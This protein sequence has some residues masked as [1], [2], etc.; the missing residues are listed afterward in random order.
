[1][2]KTLIAMT[3]VSALALGFS[4][5]AFGLGNGG[6]CTTGPCNGGNGNGN[7]HI[8]NGNSLLNVG[9]QENG[10]QSVSGVLNEESVTGNGATGI[11][12]NAAP[13]LTF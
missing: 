10:R 9:G 3:A 13:L 1:M 5:A 7:L 11:Y 6:T 8:G 12:N 2:R 4:T